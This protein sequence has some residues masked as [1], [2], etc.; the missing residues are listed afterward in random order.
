MPVQPSFGA[1]RNLRTSQ[2]VRG[3]SASSNRRPASS[4]PTR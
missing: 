2:D 1:H 3:K 4:T